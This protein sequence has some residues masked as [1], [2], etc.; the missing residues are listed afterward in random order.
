MKEI[1]SIEY[2]TLL[3]AAKGVLYEAPG[4]SFPQRG[5]TKLTS[6][7][8]LSGLLFSGDL[9]KRGMISA[10]FAASVYIRIRFAHEQQSNYFQC[11]RALIHLI[12][13]NRLSNKIALGAGVSCPPSSLVDL[14]VT[15]QL[16]A[17]LNKDSSCS[18]NAPHESSDTKNPTPSRMLWLA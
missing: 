2:I 9:P 18:K 17:F 13:H 1:T 5:H 10:P 7:R 11:L 16:R 3:R 15:R 6:A 8:S 4:H 12:L 14:F